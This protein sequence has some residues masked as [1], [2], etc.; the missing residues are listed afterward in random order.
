MNK[1]LKKHWALAAFVLCLSSLGAQWDAVADKVVADST[2]MTTTTTEESVRVIYQAHALSNVDAKRMV[3]LSTT[4]EGEDE[5]AAEIP[6]LISLIRS[7]DV[8]RFNVA[9]INFH[10]LQVALLNEYLKHPD[11]MHRNYVRMS[12]DEDIDNPFVDVMDAVDTRRKVDSTA[13]S[14]FSFAS[15]EL[16]GKAKGSYLEYSDR[17]YEYALAAYLNALFPADSTLGLG[18]MEQNDEQIPARIRSQVEGIR[19]LV[20]VGLWRLWQEDQEIQVPGDDEDETESL[21]VDPAFSA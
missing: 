17:E 18:G 15:M 21:D 4:N 13:F 14:Q 19:S 2:A 6:A 7:G 12:F 20:S 11:Q 8:E 1:N 9:Y 5:S 3:L 16:Y 10:P